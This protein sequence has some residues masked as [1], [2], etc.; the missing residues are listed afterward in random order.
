MRLHS[1]KPA[2]RWDLRA[3]KIVT[4]ISTPLIVDKGDKANGHFQS[5]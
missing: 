1:W 5:Y 3:S 2:L 4:N